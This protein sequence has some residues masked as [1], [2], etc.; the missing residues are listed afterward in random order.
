MALKKYNHRYLG[1]A[2]ESE[3]NELADSLRSQIKYANRKK[4]ANE[5]LKLLEIELCYVQNEINIRIKRRKHFR[6][7]G[8]NAR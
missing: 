3:L 7:R 5:K 8:E 2:P 1:Y 4:V 6:K